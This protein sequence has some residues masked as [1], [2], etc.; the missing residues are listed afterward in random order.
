MRISL[1]VAMDENRLIGRG[2]ALPWRLP[3][4]LQHFKRLTLGKPVVM[5]RN[6]YDSIG[7]PLPDRHHIVISRD[8][9]F[10]P[11]G[12]TVVRS[13]DEAFDVVER[14]GAKEV[15]IAG[16]ANLYKQM[17]PLAD[18]LYLTEVHGAFEG[19]A[20]FPEFDR[21]QWQVVGQERVEADERNSHA[22]T[23]TTLERSYCELPGRA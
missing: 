19:D 13:L 6:T 2:N 8:Q 23:F 20:W 14:E 4:D 12:V 10:C 16:G 11:Q 9:A 21:A 17:L 5:G 18:R 22:C 1:I 15:M 3:R 7:R